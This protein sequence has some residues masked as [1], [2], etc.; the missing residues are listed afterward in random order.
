MDHTI[1]STIARI[2]DRANAEEDG[3]SYDRVGA[4]LV[5]LMPDGMR[6]V[7]ASDYTRARLMTSLISSLIAYCDEWDHPKTP[8]AL[9]DVAV[10]AAM[11]NSLDGL[12]RKR[13]Q[14]MWVAATQPGPSAVD[15][16]AEMEAKTVYPERD[17]RWKWWRS[18]PDGA[19]DPV[20]LPTVGPGEVGVAYYS[21]ITGHYWGLREDAVRWFE[22]TR[23]DRLAREALMGA[24][25]STPPV[26]SEAQAGDSGRRRNYTPGT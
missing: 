22:T 7:A 3:R 1:E 13:D 6:L 18:L 15:E 10:Y 24:A 12:Q 17:E 25:T 11:L 4:L 23:A 14:F 16:W 26:D 5:A 20:G 19:V 21:A 9:A 2:Q 8:E